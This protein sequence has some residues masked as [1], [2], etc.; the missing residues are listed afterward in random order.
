MSGGHFNYAYSRIN[1]FADEL[2][3]DLDEAGKMNCYGELNP[4]LPDAV[5]TIMQEIIDL[6][7]YTSRLMKEAEWYFSGDTGDETF[8]ARVAVIKQEREE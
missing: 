5:K 4:E 1:L 6:A 8:L 7:E 3:N 2:A